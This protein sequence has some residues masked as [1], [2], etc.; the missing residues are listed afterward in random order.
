MADAGTYTQANG[1][2]A[3]PMSPSRNLYQLQLILEVQI[4]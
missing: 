2:R 1:C 3:R 4:L